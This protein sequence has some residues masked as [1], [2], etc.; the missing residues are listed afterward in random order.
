[1]DIVTGYKLPFTSV[2]RQNKIPKNPIL[3][4]SQ[5]KIMDQTIKDLLSA[6]AI[7]N[8]AHC[9]GK[10]ISSVFL[11]PKSNGSYR[12]IINLK[13][14]NKFLEYEHFKLEDFRV[15]RRLVTKGCYFGS[16]D[17]KDAYYHVPIWPGH[18]IF[19]RFIWKGKLYEF[20]CLPFG[21]GH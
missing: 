7:R 16:V 13:P 11:V 5:E 6:G 20:L 18:C 8:V 12:F 3:S 15:A 19:L 17:I 9:E 4:S 21:L 2:P 10:F 1:M 14:L